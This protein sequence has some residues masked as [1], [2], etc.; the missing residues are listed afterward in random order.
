MK[1]VELENEIFKVNYD[2]KQFKR[3]LGQI[4]NEKTKTCLY[5]EKERV[6]F[7]EDGN[8]TCSDEMIE[9]GVRYHF[10]KLF[11]G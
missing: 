6:W 2:P 9:N 3:I 4:E 10:F 7:D 5:C 11:E 8:I 1:L